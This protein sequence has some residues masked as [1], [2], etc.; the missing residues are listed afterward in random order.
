MFYFKGNQASKYKVGNWSRK[1]GHVR[2]LYV[3]IL[4]LKKIQR[5]WLENV[6]FICRLDE[7]FWQK[8]SSVIDVKKE[9]V[10][11]A[12][13]DGF[14]KYLAVLT[15]RASLI[16]ETDALKQQVSGEG[17]GIKARKR[18]VDVT[19][20]DSQSRFYLA[21]SRFSVGG[22]DRKYGPATSRGLREKRRE[23]SSFL[24]QTP[25]VAHTLFR[26]SLLTE[27]LERTSSQSSKEIQG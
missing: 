2:M 4:K 15:E 10:W 3:R 22:D 23:P 12:L 13:L 6:L 19:G 7:S 8:M 17:L 5:N 9:R 14:E 18:V 21:C 16:Q 25:L 1:N 26:P 11:T 24:S 20:D 27:R